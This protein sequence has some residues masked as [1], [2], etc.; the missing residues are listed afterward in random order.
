MY[1]EGELIGNTEN[2][3]IRRKIYKSHNGFIRREIYIDY[4]EQFDKKFTRYLYQEGDLCRLLRT[5]WFD[6]KFTPGETCDGHTTFYDGKV[7]QMQLMCDQNLVTKCIFSNKQFYDT[8]DTVK[9]S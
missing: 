1:R 6:R 3:F 8:L 5:I 4:Q 2:N 7:K 9:K